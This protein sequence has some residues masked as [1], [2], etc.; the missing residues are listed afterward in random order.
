MTATGDLIVGPGGATTMVKGLPVSCMG[1]MVAGAMCITGSVIMSTAMT[2]LVKG[3]PVVNMG[4]M[5]VGVGPPPL[6]PPVSTTVMSTNMT[7][8]V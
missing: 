7:V 6:C 4:S 8:I 5:V 3:R 1:D 2:K